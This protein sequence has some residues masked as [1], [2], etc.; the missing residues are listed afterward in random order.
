MFIAV[1]FDGTIV[2]HKYP[3]IGKE[4]PFAIDTL[5]KL[6]EDGH[7]IILWTVREGELLDNA[8]KFCADRG[9]RFYAVN[10]RYPGEAWSG[11]GV[12]R[13]LVADV[14]IDDSNLGGIPEW[15]TIYQMISGKDPS[16]RRHK[17][18]TALGRLIDRCK[19]SRRKFNK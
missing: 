5:I 9:L 6:Q 14:Y 2:S 7:K 17:P 4:K 1:D 11:S 8:V 16:N 10:S 18:K 3:E 15:D 13:K 12:S 19:R